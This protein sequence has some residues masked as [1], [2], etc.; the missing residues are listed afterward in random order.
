MSLCVRRTS[1]VDRQS[2]VLNVAFNDG[3]PLV[4]RVFYGVPQA[5]KD[6][7]RWLHGK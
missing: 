7:A 4:K 1:V 6:K 2:M 3:S 5:F